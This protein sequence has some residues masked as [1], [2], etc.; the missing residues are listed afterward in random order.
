MKI[1]NSPVL[2]TLSVSRTE[3]GFTP[4]TYESAYAGKIEINGENWCTVSAYVATTS[5]SYAAGFGGNL[6]KPYQTTDN[7]YVYAP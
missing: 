4:A 7:G 5:Q 3:N 1:W 2:E 6:E